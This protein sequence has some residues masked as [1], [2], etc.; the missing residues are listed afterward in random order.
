VTAVSGLP[1]AADSFSEPT[2]LVPRP[3]NHP[4]G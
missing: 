1:L 3:L 4:I 2:A